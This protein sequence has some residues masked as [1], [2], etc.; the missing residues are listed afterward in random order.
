MLKI[1]FWH[2]EKQMYRNAINDRMTQLKN[3]FNFF[4]KKVKSYKYIGLF[5][6]GRMAESWGYSFVREWG[7]SSIV[8]F[9][10]NDAKLWVILPPL[11]K[12]LWTS[13]IQYAIFVWSEE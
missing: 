9:S 10:D 1:D 4:K 8:C 3:E 12:K 7:E 13:L 5:G 2:R 6:V 11:P